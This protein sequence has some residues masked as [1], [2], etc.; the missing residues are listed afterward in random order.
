MVR[1]HLMLRVN[2]ELL[3][4][5]ALLTCKGDAIVGDEASYLF[6]LITRDHRCDVVL[7]LENV[8]EIASE[9]L[10][11]I[12]TGGEWLN[13]VGHYLFLRNASNDLIRALQAREI[14]PRT[15][16]PGPSH[17]CPSRCKPTS[18]KTV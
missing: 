12:K 5:T 7:D 14:V 16:P 1:G 4:R 10:M 6:D 11:V 8:Q 3:N 13:Q 17:C 9:G 2:L 15:R 18:R